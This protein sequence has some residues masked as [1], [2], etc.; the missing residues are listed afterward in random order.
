MNDKTCFSCR[1]I[2][3]DLGIGWSEVTPGDGFTLRCNKGH[4]LLCDRDVESA[5]KWGECISKAPGCPD[6]ED[7]T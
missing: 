1:W 5:R 3:L 6:Y 4:Y 2:D 7:R